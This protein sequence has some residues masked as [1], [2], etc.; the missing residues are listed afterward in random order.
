MR[1]S[2]PLTGLVIASL[3]LL[4]GCGDRKE[5][6]PANDRGSTAPDTAAL[7]AANDG[8]WLSLTGTI[9]S[10]TP[11]SFV[12]DYGAGNVV[13]EMD[14]WDP[15]PEGLL[16][17]AGDRVTVSGL[18]DQDLFLK[19]RIEARS[20]YV[21]NLNTYFFANNADEEELKSNALVATG[22]TTFADFTGR[23]SAIEGREFTLGT[24][25]AA[26][27]VDTSLMTDNPLDGVGLQQ[28]RLG[29]R[30]FA[31]GAIE[32]DAAE[33]A[34]LKAQ[35]LISLV[36]AG[37]VRTDVPAGTATPA[38]KQ[39]QPENSATSVTNDA[40]APATNTASNSAG[41]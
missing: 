30:V 4:A 34:E 27:R 6:A 14:D 41:T 11:N 7:S 2:A 26:I 8:Q 36:R 5:S 40:T 15:F 10:A 24:A 21:R 3:M 35:G 1:A 25:P 23:V 37:T 22:A 39:A 20:V 17:K 31:W 28:I 29:D 12:L 33:G 19:K 18:A 16:L 32:F 13:V 9:V 38:A